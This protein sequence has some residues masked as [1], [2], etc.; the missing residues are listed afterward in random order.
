VACAARRRAG[1][2]ALAQIVPSTS[3]QI[4]I[5]PNF[6]TEPLQGLNTKLAQQLTLY[7]IA[8]SSRGF[9]LTDLT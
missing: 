8:K 5:S 4:E 7:K 3:L 1:A 2:G 9:R 6:I